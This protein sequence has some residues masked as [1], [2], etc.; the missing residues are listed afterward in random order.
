MSDSL[1]PF[2]PAIDEPANILPSLKKPSSTKRVGT[3]TCCSLPIV[4]VKRRSANVASFSLINSKT[5]AGVMCV[6]ARVTIWPDHS[7]GCAVSGVQCIPRHSEHHTDL[8]QCTGLRLVVAGRTE[9][10]SRRRVSCSHVGEFRPREKAIVLVG[11]CHGDRP[12]LAAGTV[13]Q[14]GRTV[15][16]AAAR[17]D[18]LDAKRQTQPGD[19]GFRVETVV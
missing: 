9:D 8:K 14:I 18:V 5:S 4:S 16:D 3:V 11:G 2:Q 6:L 17:G 19:R 1:M 12:S 7:R 10:E 13:H 15:C